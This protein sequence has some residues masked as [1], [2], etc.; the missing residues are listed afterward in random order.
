MEG[1]TE[2]FALLS[3]HKDQVSRL[4]PGAELFAAT[5]RCPN[6]GFVMGDQV[7]AFQGHPE[8][9]REYAADLMRMREQIL[10]PDVFTAGMASL[11]HHIDTRRVARWILN[12]LLQPAA[13]EPKET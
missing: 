10:G 11:A 1:D 5:D 4:P 2:S 12:F 3:S 9:S 7:I 6:A 8:F 13:A